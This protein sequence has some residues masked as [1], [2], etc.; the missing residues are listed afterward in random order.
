M[1]TPTKDY[2]R[3]L[4]IDP[5][6]EQQAIEDAYHQLALKEHPDINSSPDATRRMQE[7]NEAYETLHDPARRAKYDVKWC[8]FVGQRRAENAA[9]GQSQPA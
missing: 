3:I 9:A 8:A 6:A 2:Y 7:I 4:Q 5:S 1:P